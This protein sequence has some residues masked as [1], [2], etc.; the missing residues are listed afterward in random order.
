MA[1]LLHTCNAHVADD[2]GYRLSCVVAAP[3]I[4]GRAHEKDESDAI[5]IL[6]Y[7]HAAVTKALSAARSCASNGLRLQRSQ[8]PHRWAR[9]ATSLPAIRLVTDDWVKACESAHSFVDS[10]PHELAGEYTSSTAGLWSFN[11]TESRKRA[12]DSRCL[13]GHTFFVTP[14]KEPKGRYTDEELQHIVRA[15]GGEVLEHLPSAS[16]G[17]VVVV[18]TEEEHK[19]WGRL[20]KMR[21]VTPIKVSHL[22]SCVLRQELDLEAG[23]LE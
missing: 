1:K 13:A 9:A 3:A 17:P 15:G 6:S 10:K 20:A 14:W 8:G 5:T 22:L 16:S 18:S 4:A 11:A 7:V 21:N 12:T 19:S 23:R 2:I